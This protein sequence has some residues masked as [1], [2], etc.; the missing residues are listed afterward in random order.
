MVIL[1][2][3]VTTNDEYG[4]SPQTRQNINHNVHKVDYYGGCA[5]NTAG[6]FRQ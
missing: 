2:L 5:T 6:V 1:F 3:F 4:L